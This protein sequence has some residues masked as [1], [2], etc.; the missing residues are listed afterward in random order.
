MCPPIV[1]SGLA[2]HPSAVGGGQSTLS[3]T[4]WLMIVGSVQK[5]ATSGRIC[6]ESVIMGDG[7]GG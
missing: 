5:V 1:R 2:D 7:G 3:G 6:A 4:I